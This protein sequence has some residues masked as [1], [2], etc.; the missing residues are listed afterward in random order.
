MDDLLKRL[1][2]AENELREAQLLVR[3]LK[4]E[5]IE[6]NKDE[7]AKALR[8][9]TEPFGT[10]KVGDIKFNVPKQVSWNQAKLEQLYKDIGET[11]SQYIK[12]KYDVSESA[13]KAWPEVIKAEFE[14]AR[15]TKTGS[16]TFEVIDNAE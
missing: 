6:E 12:V 5:I 1:R 13:Y 16:I 2:H 10:V 8:A 4:A 9:K 7:I 3:N 15:T 14:G 11:A